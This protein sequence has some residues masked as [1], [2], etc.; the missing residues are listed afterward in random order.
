MIPASKGHFMMPRRE[1]AHQNTQK[2]ISI[3][4]ITLNL[5]CL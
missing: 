4:S 3:F 1:N 5:D 2:P